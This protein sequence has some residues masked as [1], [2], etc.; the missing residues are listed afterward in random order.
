MKLKSVFVPASKSA[1][2]RNSS[3]CPATKS[4][5]LSA[6]PVLSSLGSLCVTWLTLNPDFCSVNSTENTL[7]FVPPRSSTRYFPVS[8]PVGCCITH[9]GFIGCC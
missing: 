8:L 4:Q 1:V 3:R 6:G 2:L 9:V 7:R 5:S